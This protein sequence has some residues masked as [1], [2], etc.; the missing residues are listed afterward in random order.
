MEDKVWHMAREMEKAHNMNKMRK[1]LRRLLF[2]NG[3]VDK[4][5]HVDVIFPNWGD[6]N[7]YL[8]GAFVKAKHNIFNELLEISIK[9]DHSPK[10]CIRVVI[11][12]G[13]H[14]SED[15]EDIDIPKL[16]DREVFIQEL[17]AAEKDIRKEMKKL[18]AA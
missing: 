11:Q 3:I 18:R 10:R 2:E 5:S 14:R 16:N 7:Y 4:S 17:K 6:P 13:K 12:L 1:H 9:P 8:V 15:V